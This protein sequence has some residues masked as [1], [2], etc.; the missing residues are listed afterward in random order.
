MKI[1]ELKER[2]IES[3]WTGAGGRQIRILSTDGTLLDIQQ[4]LYDADD[5][6]FYLVAANVS[7]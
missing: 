1:W 2:L 6:Q 7:P 3:M 5:D 4:V